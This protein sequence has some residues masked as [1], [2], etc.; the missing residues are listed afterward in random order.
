MPAS[1]EYLKCIANPWGDPAG[2][3]DEFSMPTAAVKVRSIHPVLTSDNGSQ[4]LILQPWDLFGTF[5]QVCG[6]TTGTSTISAYGAYNHPD[7]ASLNSYYNM[8]RSVSMG[9][10]VFYT[11]AEQ[12]T[13][14]TI[15]IVPIMSVI[16]SLT[17]MPTDLTAWTNMPDAQ[18]VAA[19]AMTEP[20]CGAC[21]SFDRPQFHPLGVTQQDRFPSLAVVVTGCQASAAVIRVEVQVNI[22]VLPKLTTAFSGNNAQPVAYDPTEMNTARRL[23][24][25]RVGNESD[26]TR[27]PR[28][29]TKTVTRK[30]K[31]PARSA[32]ARSTAVRR[33]YTAHAPTGLLQMPSYRAQYKRKPYVRRYA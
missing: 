21:H 8:Y 29:A 32:P 5:S 18:T 20:L 31:A 10:K 19:A 17:S 30:R 24:P 9:V 33:R 25:A 16:P 1:R 11:G 27:M 22:E 15:S 23:T 13:A 14:G 26:V 2:I 3:S 6:F 12:T 28:M 4:C 7:Q